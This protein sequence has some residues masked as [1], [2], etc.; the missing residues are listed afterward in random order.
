M[1]Q[2]LTATCH[3]PALHGKREATSVAISVLL[4]QIHNPDE[5][6]M[7]LMLQAPSRLNMTKLDGGLFYRID[8]ARPTRSPIQ[9]FL[10][11]NERTLSSSKILSETYRLVRKFLKTYKGLII[12]FHLPSVVIS[13]CQSSGFSLYFL[14]V[15]AHSQ[16]SWRYRG[17]YVLLTSIPLWEPINQAAHGACLYPLFLLYSS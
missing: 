4:P 16:Q 9:A 10:L 15:S 1:S 5:F 2:F 7:M 11:E 13:L 6:D 3:D 17:V 8:F 12:T 14:L